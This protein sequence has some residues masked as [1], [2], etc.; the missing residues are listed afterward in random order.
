MGSSPSK[1][2][3]NNP[4]DW[5]N[6]KVPLSGLGWSAEADLK[7]ETLDLPMTMREFATIQKYPQ[8]IAKIRYDIKKA[9]LE[10]A[11]GNV[12]QLESLLED[13]CLF[14]RVQSMEDAEPTRSFQSTLIRTLFAPRG[15]IFASQKWTLDRCG[16]IHE[17]DII[18]VHD[19]DAYFPFVIPHY[20]S[21]YSFFR[22]LRFRFLE[23]M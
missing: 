13:D 22:Y 14:S 20:K 5:D 11:A 8:K 23:G 17:Y 10:M 1:Q 3:K 7:L 16:D 6:K 12:M 18:F 2:E 21:P 9:M 15:K 19:K 4:I